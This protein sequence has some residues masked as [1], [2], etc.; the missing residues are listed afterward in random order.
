MVERIDGEHSV[1]EKLFCVNHEAVVSR[2]IAGE[3]LLVPIRNKLGDMHRI[4]VLDS[5][6]E[7]IWKKLDGKRRGREICED[8]LSAYE[9]AGEAAAADLQEFLASLADANLIVERA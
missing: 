7:F 3:T 5:V 6:G 8:V 4:Y 9:V 1:L 2:R